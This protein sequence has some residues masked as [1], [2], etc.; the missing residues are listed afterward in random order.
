MSND[1][2]EIETVSTIQHN[3]TFSDAEPRPS[4]KTSPGFLPVNNIFPFDNSTSGTTIPPSHATGAE[5]YVANTLISTSATQLPYISTPNGTVPPTAN[6]IIKDNI[7]SSYPPSIKVD[8]L[9][10]KIHSIAHDDLMSNRCIF[11]HVDLE[12]GGEECGIVQL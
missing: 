10:R 11:F 7:T 3:G 9:P 1:V 4:E 2:F 8:K 6:V 12:H 5:L